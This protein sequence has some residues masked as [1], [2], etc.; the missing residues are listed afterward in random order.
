MAIP[1]LSSNFLPP[2]IYDCSLDEIR[3][4]FGINE[5]RIDLISKLESYII[6]IKD[7]GIQG[8]II[9]DGSFVT[10]KDLP[11]D[12]DIVLVIAENEHYSI[13]NTVSDVDMTILNQDYVKDRYELHL[14]VG[15]I[16]SDSNQ[17]DET[18]SMMTELFC[19]VKYKVDQKK[20]IL[21]ILL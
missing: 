1:P 13:S 5:R 15:F 10:A 8:W 9:I 19:C 4:Y 14:F 18:A 11:G 3:G 12:I 6:K 7:S 16:D 17:A 21:R 20:G 2:G